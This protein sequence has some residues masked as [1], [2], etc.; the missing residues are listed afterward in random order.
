MRK[1]STN[2]K[3]SIWQTLKKFQK[4]IP[5][6]SKNKTIVPKNLSPDKKTNQTWK[7]ENQTTPLISENPKN[8]PVNFLLI[9]M[10]KNIWKRSH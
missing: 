3:K 10:T 6:I 9:K 5:N 1:S 8:E 4:T 2:G 7:L